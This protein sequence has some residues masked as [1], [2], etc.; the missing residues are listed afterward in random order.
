[1][2]N[3]RAHPAAAATAPVFGDG[4]VGESGNGGAQAAPLLA[5]G[6]VSEG[7]VREHDLASKGVNAASVAGGIAR[8]GTAGHEQG[9][10][11]QPPPPY[12]SV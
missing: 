11:H 5:G 2:R 12:S 7:T 4:A 1:M 6:I 3:F 10:I 9:S 8:D